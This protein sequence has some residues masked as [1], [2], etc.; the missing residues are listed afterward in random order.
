MLTTKEITVEATAVLSEVAKV[1]ATAGEIA[2][3]TGLTE[4][5]CELVLT[6]MVMA[7]LVVKD[8]GCFIRLH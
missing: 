2:Q 6:Q 1:P 3:N 4:S 7:G 5:Y 8:K